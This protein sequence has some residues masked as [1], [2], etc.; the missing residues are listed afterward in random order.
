[1]EVEQ[2]QI[3]VPPPHYRVDQVEA[4]VRLVQ[5]IMEHQAHLGKEMLAVIIQLLL[6]ALPLEEEEVLEHLD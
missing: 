4:Q 2:V 5:L 3:I 6:L 1:V